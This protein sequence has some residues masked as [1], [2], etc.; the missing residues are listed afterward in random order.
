MGTLLTAKES[1]DLFNLVLKTELKKTDADPVMRSL[2]DMGIDNI[3][4]MTCLTDDKIDDMVYDDGGTEK[5]VP[6]K[7]RKMLK[8]L[9]QWRDYVA[10]LNV[11]Q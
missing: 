1:K 11:N 3:V 9:L 2:D 7:E 10:S 5:K 6:F 4:D 8:Q